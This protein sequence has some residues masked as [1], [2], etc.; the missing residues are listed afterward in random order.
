[1]TAAGFLALVA[2]VAMGLLVAAWRYL[3][4]RGFAIVLLGLPL[5]LVYVGT[6]SASGV[7]ADSSLRPPGIV[8]VFGPVVLFMVLFAARSP[9]AAGVAARLPLGLLIG[10]QSY[11]VAVEIGLHRLNTEGLVPSVMTYA[12]GNVDIAIGL[13]APVVAWLVVSGRCGR[14]AALGWNVIGLLALANVAARAI[15]SAPGPMHLWHTE[16]PN[17]AIGLFPYTY[18]AGFFAP[19]AVL[20]H[21]LSIRALRAR[22]PDRGGRLAAAGA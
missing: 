12:G 9:A 2:A 13:S 22:S 20:L 17:V 1:M 16:V 8:Y 19:L 18:L 3:P 15:L 4:R 21:I 7:V 14:R 10:A 5:W 11:R 6:L